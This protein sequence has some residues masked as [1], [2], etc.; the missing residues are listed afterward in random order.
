MSCLY[1]EGF[2]ALNLRSWLGQASGHAGSYYADRL[3]QP[4][5]TD[6]IHSHARVHVIRFCAAGTEHFA[7]KCCFCNSSSVVFLTGLFQVA[8]LLGSCVFCFLD[9]PSMTQNYYL[10]NPKPGHTTGASGRSAR[11]GGGAGSGRTGRQQNCSPRKQATLVPSKASKTRLLV[12]PEAR[13]SE[14][15]CKPNAGT[16]PAVDER[17]NR[18]TRSALC[19]WLLTSGSTPFCLC[20]PFS[21]KACPGICRTSNLDIPRLVRLGAG[22]GRAGQGRVGGAGLGGAG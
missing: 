13:T 15:L 9:M 20:K 4:C 8:P 1:L 5:R 2:H 22:R 19:S 14:I 21:C 7:S 3:Y 16:K 12:S 11:R 6:A 10:S 17:F 18:R